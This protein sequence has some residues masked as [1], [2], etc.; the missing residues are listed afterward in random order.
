LESN[1]G[2]MEGGRHARDYPSRE[3]AIDAML[4]DGRSFG[5]IEEFISEQPVSEELKSVLWLW[6]WAEQPRVLRRQIVPAVPND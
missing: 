3:D 6:A 1:D 5:E 4:A 2:S